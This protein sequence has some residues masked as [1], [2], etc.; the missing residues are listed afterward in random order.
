VAGFALAMVIF[1]VGETLLAPTLP[2]IVNDLAAEELRGRY[3]GLS[4]LAWTVGF[5]VGPVIAGFS[6]GAGHASALFGGLVGAC[7]LAAL[8]ARRLERHLPAAA[9]VVSRPSVTAEPARDVPPAASPT[10]GKELTG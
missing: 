4:T 1:A 9:N 5:M 10:A 8:A 7:G 6:L 3:N 2:A